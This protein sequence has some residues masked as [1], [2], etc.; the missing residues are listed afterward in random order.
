MLVIFDSGTTHF[1]FSF[2]RLAPCL[3]VIRSFT[4]VGSSEEPQD[5]VRVYSRSSIN[6]GSID[7]EEP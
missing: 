5:W 7:F 1:L 4:N 2:M 3:M 6:S